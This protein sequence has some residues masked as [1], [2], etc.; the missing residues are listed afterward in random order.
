MRIYGKKI[1]MIIIMIIIMAIL[2]INNTNDGNMYFC[3]SN[4]QCV[5]NQTTNDTKIKLAD[6]M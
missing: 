1:V 6:N 3:N 5:I 4:V 2:I